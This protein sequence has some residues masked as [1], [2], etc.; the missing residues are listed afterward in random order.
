MAEVGVKQF[1]L[2]DTMTAFRVWQHSLA[3]TV[4]TYEY[5]QNWAITYRYNAL[6]TF[7]DHWAKWK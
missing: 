3:S 2:P 7:N 5:E 1:F 4:A 6:A